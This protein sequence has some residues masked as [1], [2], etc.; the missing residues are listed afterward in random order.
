M[1][2]VLGIDIGGTNTTAAV[3][4]LTGNSWTRPEI[5]PLHPRS[6]A[7]PSTLRLAPNGTL[8]V[9]ELAPF[10]PRADDGP[11][12]RGFLRRVGDNVPMMVGDETWS[13]QALTAVLATWVVDRVVALEGG[14]HA[15]Q[16]VLS[17]PAGW[18]TYR[19]ELLH[20]ALWDAGLANVTLLPEPVNAAES[21]ASRGFAGRVLAVHALGG[22]SFAASV[23]RRTP[24]GVFELLGTM[25]GVDP[26]GG[27]DFDEA[28]ARHVR[29]RLSQQFRPAKPSDTVPLPAL[30]G[31]CAEAKRQLTVAA[32]T[33]SC[34]CRRERPGCRSPGPSSSR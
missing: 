33:V 21:H 34:T 16:I 7:I 13:P 9:D 20:R 1:P 11:V 28:L 24:A 27:A 15:A 25:E 6:S 30:V 22:E 23:V 19:K 4:R 14:R 17:H 32:A 5:V 26:L 29:D 8:T 18:G 2:Y 10:S 12:A 3:S 31:P